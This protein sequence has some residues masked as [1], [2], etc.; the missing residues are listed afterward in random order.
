MAKQPCFEIVVGLRMERLRNSSAPTSP[1]SSLP[2]LCALR[3]V[4]ICRR[5]PAAWPTPSRRPP[6]TTPSPDHRRCSRLPNPCFPRSCPRKRG[7]AHPL[8]PMG[9]E[10]WEAAYPG[11]RAATPRAPLWSPG[12]LSSARYLLRLG[13]CCCLQE[14]LSRYLFRGTSP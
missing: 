11:R 9:A 7:R 10:S 4:W 1:P 14:P 8:A 2:A 3:F 13:L 5:V 6:G 12:L